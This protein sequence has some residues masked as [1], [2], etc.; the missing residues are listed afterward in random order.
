MSKEV[1]RFYIMPGSVP[2]LLSGDP[3][4]TP[5][6]NHLTD[7]HTVPLVLASDY[8][9]LLAERDAYKKALEKLARV[10]GC[11][12]SFPCRCGGEEWTRAELEGRMD[13]AAETLTRAA[14]Q[15]AQP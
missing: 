15:G 11:G 4:Y 10:P 6:T 9:A 12:C 1:K 13:Y 5:M 3:A 14:L 2:V 8:D 7:V